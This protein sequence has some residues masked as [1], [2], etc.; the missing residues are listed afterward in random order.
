MDFSVNHDGTAGVLI[1]NYDT[2]R[3]YYGSANVKMPPEEF[4][5]EWI[6]ETTEKDFADLEE[7][8]SAKRQ[9]CKFKEG[10]FFRFKFD[11]RHYGYG[12]VLFDV[13]KWVKSGGEFW[14]VL[15]GRA[16][17]VSIFC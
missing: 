6:A 1:G 2:Q 15:M 17:C 4:I 13:Y 7:F 8:N 12:R 9:H 16:V 10:D 5:R 3:T 11:R 14:D